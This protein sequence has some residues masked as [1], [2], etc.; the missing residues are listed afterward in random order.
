M[1]DYFSHDYNARNDKKLARAFMKHGLQAIG[2]YWCIVEMLYEEG[3]YLPLSEYERITFELR[4]TKSV[5]NYLIYD[6]ELFIND[7]INFWTE[8][9]IE[10]LKLRSEK[11]DKARKNIGI[12]W[13]KVAANTNV[14]QT[15]IERNTIKESKVKEIKEKNLVV[16]REM[17]IA[18][19]LKRKQLFYDSLIPFL[20]I[21][22]KELIKSFYDYWSETNKIQTKMRFEMEKTFETVK[23]L[24]TW[25]KNESKFNKNGK[26]NNG[27]GATSDSDLLDA[28][29]QGVG[30]A[31]MQ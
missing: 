6:S 20:K 9:G 27:T 28:I 7:G 8:S 19:T 31:A 11:S 18:N 1:R 17:A 14:L 22:S 29:M 25:N 23:R 4:T 21:Y 5:I 13:N 24:A 30:R 3:G 12:R 15:N 2:G 16:S 10:R 26:N